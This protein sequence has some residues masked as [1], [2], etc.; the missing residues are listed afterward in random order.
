MRRTHGELDSMSMEL[1]RLLSADKAL[2][3][4]CSLVDSN[5]SLWL[6]LHRILESNGAPPKRKQ[7]QRTHSVVHDP[8]MIHSI[9]DSANTVLNHLHLLQLS[10]LPVDTLGVITSF[11]PLQNCLQWSR[12]NKFFNRMVPKYI[13]DIHINSKIT[14]PI[15]KLLYKMDHLRQLSIDGFSF[16]DRVPFLIPFSKL[17]SVHTM[18]FQNVHFLPTV[19]DQYRFQ[20]GTYS[21][22]DLLLNSCSITDRQQW[23][24]CTSDTHSPDLETLRVILN[25]HKLPLAN[26]I[27]EEEWKENSL[28]QFMMDLVSSTN[29]SQIRFLSLILHDDHLLNTMTMNSFFIQN[30]KK[31]ELGLIDRTPYNRYNHDQDGGTQISVLFRRLF[32]GGNGTESDPESQSVNGTVFRN[33]EM[34]LIDFCPEPHSNGFNDITPLDLSEFSTSIPTVFP[35]LKLLALYGSHSELYFDDMHLK[36]L[37]DGH[38]LPQIIDLSLGFEHLSSSSI[39]HVMND[40][41]KTFPNVAWLTLEHN[42]F[43]SD[44]EQFTRSVIRSVDPEQH[45]LEWVTLCAAERDEIAKLSNG[46]YIE[47]WDRSIGSCQFDAALARS[48]EIVKKRSFEQTKRGGIQ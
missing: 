35:A 30:L 18:T 11:L 3:L 14:R 33:L 20:G 39:D 45:N 15:Y 37:L 9:R 47:Y 17:K 26:A 2:N 48:K 32:A 6:D 31:L 46:V 24:E 44:P 23:L 13:V 8:N 38:R 36:G 5:P 41:L 4:L 1:Q 19:Q 21:V 40:V 16:D 25:H 42:Q 29:H 10:E 27:A 12:C 7:S 22:R 28:H 43:L 34:L